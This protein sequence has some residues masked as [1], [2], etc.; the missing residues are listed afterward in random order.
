[1]GDISDRKPT[2]YTAAVV[3]HAL[4]ERQ[5]DAT[6]DV[7]ASGGVEQDADVGMF[8]LF[9]GGE[10]FTVVVDRDN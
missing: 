7:A 10:C 9:F 5:N 2:G 1:M 8:K 4:V 3:L 6:L